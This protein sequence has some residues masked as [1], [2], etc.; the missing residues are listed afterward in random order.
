MLLQSASLTGLLVV[1]LH[2]APRM[3]RR[4]AIGGNV[5][6]SGPTRRYGNRQIKVSEG[7]HHHAG[8]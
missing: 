4:A 8:V 1:V 3:Q 6:I 5:C 2:L 7:Q